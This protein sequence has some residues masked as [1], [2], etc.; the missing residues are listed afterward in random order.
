MTSSAIANK[1]EGTSAES[2]RQAARKL[3][4]QGLLDSAPYSKGGYWL[5]KKGLEQVSESN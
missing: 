1:V 2:I 3:V 5:T 4:S